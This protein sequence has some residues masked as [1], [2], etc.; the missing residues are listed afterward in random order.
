MATR[1]RI[2]GLFGIKPE[3]IAI[4]ETQEGGFP[5]IFHSEDV[6]VCGFDDWH[7]NFRIVIRVHERDAGRAVRLTTLVRRNNG[8]GYCYIFL[9][10]PVHKLIVRRLLRNLSSR[11]AQQR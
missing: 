3:Q 9:I 5:V 6:V 1:N 2:V 4:G 11:P 8:F 7:L 10:S